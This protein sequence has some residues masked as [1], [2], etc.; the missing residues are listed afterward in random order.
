MDYKALE[1]A[2]LFEDTASSAEYNSKDMWTKV[3][4]QL[5][6]SRALYMGLFDVIVNTALS[7]A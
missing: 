5:L 1:H 2:A 4:I 3:E 6:E 7:R